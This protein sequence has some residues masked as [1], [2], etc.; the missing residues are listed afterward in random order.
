MNDLEKFL[1]LP[2]VDEITEDVFVSKRL[3][4]FKVRAMSQNELKTYQKRAQG[5]INKNGVDFDSAK[6]NLLI[7]AGQTVEPDF[8]NAELLKKS[9]CTTAEEFISKKLLAGEIGTL[10]EGIQKISFH[11]FG[12]GSCH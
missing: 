11:I 10:V 6:F 1:A 7:A 8:A 9:G 5:K 3:G 12:N 2:N 4:K